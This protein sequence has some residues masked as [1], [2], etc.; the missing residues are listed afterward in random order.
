MPRS[1]CEHPGCGAARKRGSY[2]LEHGAA[3]YAANQPGPIVL[4]RNRR[5]EA[6]P[7]FCVTWRERQEAREQLAN[8]SAIGREDD[9]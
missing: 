6:T 1:L 7:P 3:I 5:G 4:S 9:E 2:C 8:A